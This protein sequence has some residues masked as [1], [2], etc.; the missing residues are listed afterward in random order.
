LIEM[1]LNK[2]CA[3]CCGG[4]GGLWSFNN[5]VSLES[6]QTRLKED[7][8]KNVNILTTACPQCQLNFRF[9][10]HTGNSNYKSLKIYDITELIDLALQS[11]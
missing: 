2:N 10:S 5:K 4:G 11:E 3:R 7:L 8:P 1:P 9:A 6:T